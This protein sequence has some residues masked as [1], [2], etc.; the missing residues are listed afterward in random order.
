MTCKALKPSLVL[1]S[2]FLA[3]CRPAKATLPLGAENVAPLKA[4]ARAPSVTVKTVDG[5]DFDL[6]Q[7][8]AAKPTVLMFY[9]GGWCP[10]CNK[11]LSGIQDYAPRFTALGY[12][13]LA[14]CTDKPEDLRA[15]MDKHQLTYT[16]LSDRAMEAASAFQVAFRVPDDD[17]KKY[18]S[19]GVILPGIPGEPGAQWLPV[20]SIFIVGKDGVIKFAEF[21]PNFRI[22]PPPEEILAAAASANTGET[23]K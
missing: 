4:G 13:I 5:A 22:R 19:H 8:F 1:A 6:G 21:N 23:S 12:Q 10:F 18:A 7:A 3:L 16:L 9:R 15:T 17:A 11:Q 2:A 14:V 20:P